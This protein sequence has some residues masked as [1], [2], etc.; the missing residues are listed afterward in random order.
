[1]GKGQN[2]LTKHLSIRGTHW[3]LYEL[4]CRKHIDMILKW[5][6]TMKTLGGLQGNSFTWQGRGCG[7][8]R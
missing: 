7:D 6:E 2:P 1:M 3:A 4:C 5:R 8:C